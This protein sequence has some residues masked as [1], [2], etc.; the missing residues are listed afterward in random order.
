MRTNR[1]LFTSTVP[2]HSTHA[3]FN[4]D[5]LNCM[6]L[7]D[8]KKRNIVIPHFIFVSDKKKARICYTIYGKGLSAHE[9]NC[10]FIRLEIKNGREVVG[11]SS[12]SLLFNEAKEKKYTARSVSP[13]YAT[14]YL[15]KMKRPR[16]MNLNMEMEFVLENKYGIKDTV[17]LNTPLNK[18]KEKYT[19]LFD[20]TK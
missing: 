15:M 1:L 4:K 6:L 20:P 2:L 13:F 8:H 17:R 7:V 19:G 3:D 11:R 12:D 18:V 5:S 14:N 10:R 16:E 9:Y